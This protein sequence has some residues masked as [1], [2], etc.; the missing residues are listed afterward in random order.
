[1]GGFLEEEMI[2]RY[3]DKELS[4]K[5]AVEYLKALIEY[6]ESIPEYELK[7]S[8]KLPMYSYE[9]VESLIELLKQ[10]EA[11]N[12]ILQ[13]KDDLFKA[14]TK[15]YEELKNKYGLL[16]GY[17]DFLEFLSNGGNIKFGEFQKDRKKVPVYAAAYFVERLFYHKFLKVP[18]E[19]IKI[20]GEPWEK[21]NKA[22][23]EHE[24]GSKQ[25]KKP[26]KLYGDYNNFLLD[27]SIEYPR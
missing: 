11:E 27:L 16:G 21:Y 17:T 20:N 14:E 4:S 26:S 1:M 9:V 19:D 3:V 6:Y 13:R 8:K 22:L 5:E 2:K 10:K 18:L 25:K 24:S 23:K 15:I 7:E 12:Q